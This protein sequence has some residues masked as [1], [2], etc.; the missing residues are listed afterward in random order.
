MFYEY[1]KPHQEAGRLVGI[2]ELGL[3]AHFSA[4]HQGPGEACLG[5]GL[6]RRVPAWVPSVF[7]E[8]SMCVCLWP[9]PEFPLFP[10]L[11]LP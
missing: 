11:S 8:L 6:H 4:P 5:I 3:L 2:W 7:S 9:M 1:Q 10:I